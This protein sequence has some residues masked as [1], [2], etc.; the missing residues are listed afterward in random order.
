LTV[1]V[2]ER[3]SAKNALTDPWIQSFEMM[4]DE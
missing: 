1:D 2:E 3:Y 4:E